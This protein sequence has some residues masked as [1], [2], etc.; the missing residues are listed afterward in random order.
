MRAF[1]FALMVFLFLV[2]VKLFGDAA[3]LLTNTYKSQWDS[4]TNN[5][6]MNPFVG[7][8]LGIF[9]TAIMQ[10]SSATTSIA[11]AMVAAGTIQLEHAVPFVMGANIGTSITSSI[12]SLGHIGER[13][14]FGRAYSASALQDMFNIM[15]T[16]VLLPLEICFGYLSNLARF[17]V[18]FLPSGTG[19]SGGSWNP[20]PWMVDQPVDFVRWVLDS[21]LKTNTIIALLMMILALVI[22][23]YALVQITK[24]M[25]V[26]MDSRLEEMMNRVL[27]K[28]GYLGML[29]GLI[30]TMIIQSSSITTS[31]LVPLV[32]SGVLKLEMA[33]PILV[34]ANIGTTITALLAAMAFSGTA[35]VDAISVA[36]VHV[37]F[38]CSGALLWYPIPFM[39]LP[40]R[41]AK[42]LSA[43]STL[44]RKYVFMWLGCVFFIIPLIGLWLFS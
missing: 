11:V 33:Y 5:L 23:F 41:G 44:S 7:L 28:N 29:I 12:V 17:L 15:T 20:L 22:L 4:L 43:L 27:A 42:F 37:L 38:N 6:G 10:S 32:A 31:L 26:L 21:C 16:A 40:V 3:S 9:L 39:R 8:C 19:E 36:L 14:T 13:K 1:L 25:K 35:G 24:N 34:G 18:G 2:A 30:V